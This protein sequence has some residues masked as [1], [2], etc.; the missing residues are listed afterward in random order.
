MHKYHHKLDTNHLALDPCA[1]Q[2]QR[3]KKRTV[4]DLNTHR[5]SVERV[6]FLR[7]MTAK[8][9]LLGT[10]QVYRSEQRDRIAA[11]AGG[12][13]KKGS[14]RQAEE[15]LEQTIPG[16]QRHS[17]FAETIQRRIICNAARVGGTQPLAPLIGMYRRLT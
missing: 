17:S 9:M 2:F 8:P 15:D 12:S 6:G 13:V 3:S 14:W 11:G 1:F 16:A 7:E 4:C 10:R 5:V